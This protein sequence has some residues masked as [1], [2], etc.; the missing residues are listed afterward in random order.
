MIALFSGFAAGLSLIVAIGAQNAFVI[1][2]GLLRS[3]VLLVVLFCALSDA[4]LIVAGV[5]GLGA[6]IHSAPRALEFIRWFGVTYLAWFALKTFLQ[7]FTTQSLT[8]AHQNSMPR[9]KV[10]ASL[11][12]FTYLNPHVYLD[13]VIFLGSISNQFASQKWHFALGASLASLLWFT[14]IGFAAQSVSRYMS[15]AIFWKIFDSFVAL[16]MAAIAIMLATY[17]FT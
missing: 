6:I 14:V 16:V 15:R 17:S 5:G 12:A 13:T 9:R 11:F 2:Q 10:I 3:H 1:R 8:P 7:I 4:L